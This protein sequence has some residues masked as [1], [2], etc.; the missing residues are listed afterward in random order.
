MNGL[1]KTTALSDKVCRADILVSEQVEPHWGTVCVRRMPHLE[2][3][4]KMGYT[5]I[6]KTL[7]YTPIQ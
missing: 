4:I 1:S 2:N 7:L 6:L 5:H 3:V